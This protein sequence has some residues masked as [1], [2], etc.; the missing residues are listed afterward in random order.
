M[1]FSYLFNINMIMK[2][3]NF[4][5]LSLFFVSGFLYSDEREI[6]EDYIYSIKERMFTI[7]REIHANPELSNR[8]FQTSKRVAEY[9]RKLGLDVREK[10]AKTGVIG[11]LWKGDNYPTLA[12]RADMDALPIEE[13]NEVEYRSKVKGVMHACGHDFHTTILL[14]TAD[15]LTKFKDIV[16]GNVVFIF[17]PAEEGAPPGEEGGASLMIKEGLFKIFKPSCIFALHVTPDIEV[18]KVG[19][20]PGYSMANADSFK[21]E[22]E[23]KSSHGAYPHQGIDAIL[24]SS[25]FITQIQSIPSR[26]SDVNDPVVITIGRIQGGVRSNVLAEKV[27][28]EGT[29]RTLSD[30]SRNMVLDKIN[31][32]LKG[33]EISFGIK[34][35]LDVT[36]QVP[37]VYNSPELTEWSISLIKN[38]LGKGNCIELKPQ[39]TAEDFGF[40]SREVPAFHFWLGVR[41]EE[42]GFIHGLHTPYFNGDEGAIPIGIKIFVN[43]VM[44]RLEKLKTD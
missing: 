4:I 13:K 16:K 29:I 3:L 18:G 44:K 37:S 6:V 10:I 17:Q 7:R 20:T 27:E 39:M 31:N 41:N 22:I 26:F 5:F 30:K 33:I 2:K 28:M 24:A 12:I 1:T 25:L 11:V 43:L 19:Y 40:Y 36:N 9:L 15:V 8:E 42:K 23:G 34:Y 14:G 38:I 35:R 32:I 21:I